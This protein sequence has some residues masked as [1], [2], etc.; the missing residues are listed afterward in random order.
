MSEACRVLETPVIS[1]NVSLYNETNG[2]AIYPTPI[3]GMVGVV[4]HISH[5]TTQTFKQPGDLIYVIGEAKQ[6]FG[7][8]ELQKWLTGR[9]FGK[10]PTIDLHVEATRQRQLLTAIRAGVVASAHDVSEG[11]LAVALAECLIDAQG[12]G[13]HVA[14]GG[15]VVSELFSETQ[16]RFVVSVKKNI[17]KRSNNSFKQ[18]VSGK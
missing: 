18:Y 15:D 6:E 16:S 1:G 14:I 9:I 17:N 13:A 2:E 12:L 8:S 10:A 7:G 3:V 4:E 11:G 5:I